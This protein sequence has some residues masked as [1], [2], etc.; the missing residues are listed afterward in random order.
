MLGSSHHAITN[1]NS[2]DVKWLKSHCVCNCGKMSQFD[3]SKFV[4][5]EEKIFVVLSLFKKFKVPILNSLDEL[6]T[7]T[8]PSSYLDSALIEFENL[9]DLMSHISYVFNSKDLYNNEPEI[10][11]VN[12]EELHSRCKKIYFI[13]K[14]I[15]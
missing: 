4:A 6:A 15:V 14:I 11:L 10:F 5:N 1:V 7:N 13:N 12:K 9:D 8:T 3:G 2:E